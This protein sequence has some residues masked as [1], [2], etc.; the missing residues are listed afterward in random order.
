[1]TDI[2][3]VNPPY[4]QISKG[5]DYVKHVTNRSPSIGLLFLAA[6]VRNGGYTPEII[7]SD[8]ENLHPKEVVAKILK[9]KPRF[10]GI[11]L[12]TVGV[13][14]AAIIAKMLQEK[15]PEITVIV[16][17]P[18]MS[19]MGIETMRKFDEFDIGVI[20]EGEMIIN[21]L[22][23]A[24]DE[25]TD[26]GVIP[27]LMYRQDAE[28]KITPPPA[29][30]ENLDDL[31]MPAWDILPNFPH[32]YLPAI[33]D[34]PRAPV[35]TY[36]ASRG[37]PFKCEFCD[38]STFGSKVRYNSP[39]KVYE[40]M[41]HLR[42]EYG[43]KHLQFIDDLFVAHN[44]I[45]LGLCEL[46]IKDKIDITWSC[47]ARV[48]T[49]ELETLKKM[50]EAG[51]WEISFGLESGDNAMLKKMHKAIRVE[52]SVKAVNWA[53]EAGIRVKG[54]MMLGYPGETPESVA[55]TK[56]FIKSIPLTTMNLSK[57]TPYPGSPIYKKLY[58]VAIK[59]EDWERLNGMNFVYEPEG[60]TF[61]ELN[62]EYKETI[63]TFYK[64]PHILKHYQS[65]VFSNPTHLIRLMRFG[66][67]FFKSKAL[68][69]VKQ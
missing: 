26:L 34:Y 50:K 33:F 31:P 8:I 62:K 43:V 32:G 41:K 28:I 5:H 52:Q 10:V 29:S 59:E 45:V 3:F 16:G 9:M 58:N 49:V 40:I 55:I 22:L 23:C 27:G 57:F 17:G 48:D 60:F 1:M 4:E 6:Q 53:H 64:R 21:D 51:C 61:D 13:F 42:E 25:K 18:H 38:T 7:E 46:L 56:E 12:F 24:L 66:L 14:N 15:A 63:K 35:A 67:G 37:C 2:V 44:D 36:A 65:M 54:L 69:F 30:I 11:T 47:T 68:R 19:S 20:Y 39:E